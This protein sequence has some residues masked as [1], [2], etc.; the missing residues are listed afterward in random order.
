MSYRM[1]GSCR[2]QGNGWYLY[3]FKRYLTRNGLKW[4]DDGPAVHYID[5]AGVIWKVREDEGY[6][7]SE[8]VGHQLQKGE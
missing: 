2:D 5:E 8:E 7:V 4:W 6:L 1:S 3:E